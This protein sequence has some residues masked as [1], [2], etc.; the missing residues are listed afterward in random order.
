MSKG[1]GKVERLILESLQRMDS[2]EILG[3]WD[4]AYMVHNGIDCFDRTFNDPQPEKPPY[5]VYQSVCR[6]VR[7]LEQKGII[8]GRKRLG[9]ESRQ[10]NMP[11]SKCISLSV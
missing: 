11:W 7:K 10:D 9:W 6:A 8:R 2:H 1:L 4:L 3:V 5:V